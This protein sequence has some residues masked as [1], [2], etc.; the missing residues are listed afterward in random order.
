MTS[1]LANTISSEK[2]D[3]D[4][5]TAVTRAY[6]QARLRN[7][8]FNL[9]LSKFRERADAGELTKAQL[10]R[11]MGRKPEVVNRLLG[12]P[13]NWTIDTVSDLLLAIAGEELDATSSDPDR[14]PPRNASSGEGHWPLPSEDKPFIDLGRERTPYK[15]PVELELTN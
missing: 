7:R 8:L 13:G 6:F 1:S 10:A 9:V 12:A 14:R 4:T 3:L 2:A 5:L 15:S 11:R